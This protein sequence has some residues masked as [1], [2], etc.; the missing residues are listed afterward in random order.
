MILYY[1]T[2]QKTLPRLC[3]ASL[4]IRALTMTFFI[5]LLCSIFSVWESKETVRAIGS[6]HFL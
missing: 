1:L 2:F 6:V 5:R 3:E 4:S